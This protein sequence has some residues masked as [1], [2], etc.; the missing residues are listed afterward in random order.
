MYIL[1]TFTGR[2]WHVHNRNV[3]KWIDFEIDEEKPYFYHTHYVECLAS[4]NKEKDILVV[5]LRNYKECFLR[6]LGSLEAMEEQILNTHPLYFR[7]LT[8]FDGWNPQNRIL[9]YY[10]N[11]MNDGKKEVERLLTFLGE[12]LDD[13][14]L[15]F[16]HIDEHR[17]RVIHYY[18][19][20]YDEAQSRGE[21]LL[22]IPKKFLWKLFRGSILSYPINIPIYG[23]NILSV[24]KPI[25]CNMSE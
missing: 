22:F 19:T 5:L 20:R 25:F 12:S 18:N 3:L 11:L 6:S 2:S 21:D 14:D 23:K 8:Y 16:E 17:E 7:N 10:E 24:L 15:F 9:I 1:Q 4:P 13:V